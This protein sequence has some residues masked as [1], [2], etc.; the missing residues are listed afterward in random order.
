MVMAQ[1]RRDLG[2]YTE[3][4]TSLSILLFLLSLLFLYYKQN[5]GEQDS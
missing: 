4:V 3:N 5:H 2:A 1:P